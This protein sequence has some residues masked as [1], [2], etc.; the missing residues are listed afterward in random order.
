[1][2]NSTAN[3]STNCIHTNI[4]KDYQTIHLKLFH[5]LRIALNNLGTSLLNL[6][7]KV[8]QQLRKVGHL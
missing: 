3:L 4:L 8:E 7:F 1:M 5:E 6:S 2:I